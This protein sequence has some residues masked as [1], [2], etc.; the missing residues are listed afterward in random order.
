MQKG[1]GESENAR[2]VGG[3]V[4]HGGDHGGDRPMEKLGQ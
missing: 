4:K 2:D 1:R 3:V